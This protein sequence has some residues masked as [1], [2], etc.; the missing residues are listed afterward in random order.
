MAYLYDE[1]N[2]EE[3]PTQIED[4]DQTNYIRNNIL[5]FLDCE[6]PIKMP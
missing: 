3:S 6:S 5:S 4:I 2:E 1:T